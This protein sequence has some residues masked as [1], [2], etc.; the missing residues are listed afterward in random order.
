MFAQ[1]SP[2]LFRDIEY[3]AVYHFT[4]FRDV[5]RERPMTTEADEQR[6]WVSS[7]ITRLDS[8]G[9][10]AWERDRDKRVGSRSRS[11][12]GAAKMSRLMMQIGRCAMKTLVP[13]GRNDLFAQSKTSLAA[14]RSITTTRCLRGAGKCASPRGRDSEGRRKKYY[15]GI[16]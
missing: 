9:D 7:F 13:Q 10:R 15:I 14:W 3:L 12:R 6:I 11:I 1:V 16:N 8:V 5:I 2:E 4:H